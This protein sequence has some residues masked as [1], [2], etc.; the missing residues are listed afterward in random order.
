MH[1]VAADVV[2]DRRTPTRG[3]LALVSMVATF[4]LIGA[5]PPPQA[6]GQLP[7]NWSL[8]SRES[9]RTCARNRPAPTALTL[10]SRAVATGV[11]ATTD[12][13]FFT[14]PADSGLSIAMTRRA[15]KARITGY[16]DVRNVVVDVTEAFSLPATLRAEPGTWS[17]LPLCYMSVTDSM[18]GFNMGERHPRHG[19]VNLVLGFDDQQYSADRCSLAHDN[20]YWGP[21]TGEGGCNNNHWVQFCFAKVQARTK[22]EDEAVTLAKKIWNAPLGIMPPPFLPGWQ[23]KNSCSPRRDW[24]ELPTNPRDIPAAARACYGSEGRVLR[25]LRGRVLDVSGGDQRNGAKVILWSSRGA[26][27][28]KWRMVRGTGDP[29]RYGY[30]I[31]GFGGKCL[32]TPTGSRPRPG[33]LVQMWDCNN[34]YTQKWHHEHGQIRVQDRRTPRLCLDVDERTSPPTAIVAKCASINPT[35]NPSQQWRFAAQ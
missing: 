16:V 18:Y 29:T 1:A 3:A 17:R 24:I 5:S 22:E 15:G 10:T 23:A 25:G 12:A 28:Q 19:G 30:E 8:T 7:S 20:Y 27:N 34:R 4:V 31:R 35:R 2:A 14:W 33:H 13:N 32:G 9:F 11:R 26:C 21:T 6:F